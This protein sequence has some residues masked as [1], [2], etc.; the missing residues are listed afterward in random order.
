MYM[1]SH[2]A[3]IKYTF[4]SSCKYLIYFLLL[5]YHVIQINKISDKCVHCEEIY[6]I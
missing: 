4:E 3:C 6:N 5:F 2:S 1:P